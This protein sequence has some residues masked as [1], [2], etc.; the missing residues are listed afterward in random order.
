MITKFL[1]SLEDPNRPLI[2]PNYWILRKMG[3]ILPENKLGKALYI[4]LHGFASFFVLTQYMELFAIKSSLDLVLT[5]LKISML[6]IV[7]IVKANTFVFWQG[8]WRE[9]FDYV[10]KADKYE[11]DSKDPVKARI[12]DSYTKYC[13]RV[14]HFYWILICMT[15]VTVVNTPLLMYLSSSNYR[16]ALH[17]GTELFPH[18]FSSWVPFDKY[19]PPGSWIMI[20]YHTV[21]CI[22]G[23]GIMAA[24]DT[25]VMVI[26]VFIGGKMDLL[27]VR[28]KQIFGTNDLGVDDKQAEAN[29][30]ELHDIYV[31]LMKNSQLFNS[32]LSPVMFFYV[33]MCS[34]VLC[35]SAFQLTSA[36]DATQK[37]LMAEY[38]VF[39]IT[40][41]FLFCWH[42][43]DVLVKSGNV[44]FGPY[45]SEWWTAGL[46]Q[47]RNILLLAGQLR[48]VHMFTA[49]PFTNLTLLTF[50][51][52]LR[53]AYSYYTLLK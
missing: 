43:N 12:V 45:E 24:Y 18:I 14:V 23:G 9:L 44:T 38:L 13:R 16:K 17:N 11:R 52:I 4:F 32:L 22:Y 53:G 48:R 40:Q 26:M 3:L 6:S 8:K 2:G 47:R 37:L 46:R 35:F 39:G 19:N 20:L 29:I 21:M 51:T 25:S 34:S 31:L 5:N 36:N 41:L 7:C 15:V 27:R 33:I 50:I 28:C 49:G 30:R 10:C 42:S 1:K